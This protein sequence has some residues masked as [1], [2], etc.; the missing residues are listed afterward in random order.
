MIRP[1][2]VVATL[3]MLGSAPSTPTRGGA[4]V[5][6]SVAAAWRARVELATKRLEGARLDA[7]D[8]AVELAFKSVEVSTKDNQRRFGLVIEIEGKAMLVAW[9]YNGQKLVDFSIGALPPKWFL[10]QVAG[11]KTL[12]VLPAELDCA[13]DL[14]PPSPL[15]N[16]PCPGE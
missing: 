10:R 7:C 11:Q 9:S 4:P 5:A 2:I 14:C 12:T 8:R 3:M 16:G 13:L 6:D 15:A 1:L